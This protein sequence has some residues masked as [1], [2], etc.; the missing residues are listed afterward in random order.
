MRRFEF[1]DSKSAKFWAIDRQGRSFTVTFGKIGSAGQTQTKDFP[2]E[3]AAIQAHDKLVAE[4]VGKGYVEV[5]AAPAPAPAPAKPTRATPTEVAPTPAA[6]APAPATTGSLRTFVYSDATSHKFWNIELQG[7]RFTVTY[8]KVSAA[9][10]TQIKDFP[11]EAMARKEHDKLVR[12]KLGK[13]YLETTPA[14]QGAAPAGA[15]S[16]RDSLEVAIRA[17]PDDRLAYSAYGDYLQE[18][19][20]PRGEFIAVQLGLEDPSL[21]ARER[22]KLQQ[23]EKQLLDAHEREWLGSTLADA[24]AEAR[25]DDGVTVTFRRGWLWGLDLTEWEESLVSPVIQALTVA[26]EARWLHDLRIEHDPQ[27]EGE[28]RVLAG[29]P[30]VPILRQLQLGEDE[31]QTHCNGAG[32]AALVAACPRLETLAV[33]AHLDTNEAARLFAAPMPAVRE[34]AVCCTHY[35]P[36]DRLAKN[37]TLTQLRALRLVPHMLEYRDVAYLGAADLRPLGNSPHL[38][39]LADLKFVLWTGGDAAVDALV[40]TG[41]LF[42]LERLDLS[43]GNLTDAG[44]AALARALGSRSHSLRYLEVSSNAVTPAGVTTL[45]GTGVEVVCNSRHNPDNTEYLGYYGDPE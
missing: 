25:E 24:I 14:A 18:Q 28:I 19:G 1:R 23:R 12:E 16:V 8:G 32:V 10:Q 9:G 44:A 11:D 7:K 45:Q 33:H 2:T 30:F 42:R 35:Y 13:G 36:L 15:V 3:A 5:A 20:D 34:L 4:K 27:E 31:T 29:A 21:P 26:Q 22:K 37:K 41:L 17:N 43:Y 39:A 40:E 6:P 38:K